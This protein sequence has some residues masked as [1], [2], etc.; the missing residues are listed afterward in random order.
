MPAVPS[1]I[2]EPIWDQ[3]A[4]LLPT[5][6]TGHPLGCHCRRIPDRLIFDKLVQ[7]LVIGCA[8]ARIADATC[9]ASTLRC[10]RDEWIAAGVIEAL[11]AIAQA[12]C[13]ALTGSSRRSARYTTPPAGAPGWFPGQERRCSV[14][15]PRP[16]HQRRA[17][18]ASLFSTSAT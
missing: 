9:S 15:H 3:F 12:L 11:P 5:G 14:G 17:L 6:E 13:D 2:I 1:S 4:A 16:E 8:D 10:R 18:G 7:V